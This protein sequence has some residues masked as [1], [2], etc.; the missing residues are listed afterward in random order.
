[1]LTS[2]K[3]RPVDAEKCIRTSSRRKKEKTHSHPSRSGKGRI[4]MGKQLT[5]ARD[6]GD[7]SRCIG[8]IPYMSG[9]IGRNCGRWKQLLFSRSHFHF[10]EARYW[11]RIRRN[12]T[13]WPCLGWAMR[14][15]YS[16]SNSLIPSLMRTW[17]VKLRSTPGTA[18]VSLRISSRRASFKKSKIRRGWSTGLLWH[19]TGAI[20]SLAGF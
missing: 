10:Y 19:A 3:S 17:P 6:C 12:A 9:S 11:I 2:G 1:M 7:P 14:S 20:G 5:S 4:G 16:F 8:D 13:K 18:N 15:I